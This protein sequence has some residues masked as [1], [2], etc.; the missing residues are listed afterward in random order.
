MVAA[1]HLMLFLYQELRLGIFE[2]ARP[3]LGLEGLVLSLHQSTGQLHQ[4]IQFVVVEITARSSSVRV[5]FGTEGG[6][7]SNEET[8]REQGSE[9]GLY[10]FG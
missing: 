2:V 7:E 8:E 10:L 3:K 4:P 6:H 5:N 1:A 9:R